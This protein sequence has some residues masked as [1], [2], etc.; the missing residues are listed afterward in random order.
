M[1]VSLSIYLANI[2]ISL[3]R[4]AVATDNPWNASSLEWATSSPPPPYNFIPSPTVA[5]R[6][7]LWEAPHVEVPAVVGLASDKR[8]VLVTQVMDA[9]PDH[10][11]EFPEPTIWPFLTAFATGA[12][13]LGSIFTPWA[14]IWGSIPIAVGLIGWAW[15][16][17]GHRPHGIEEHVAQAHRPATEHA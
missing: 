7:P 10:R 13:Y 6:E 16:R 11:K 17:K 1:F 15:P 5:G 4:G 2:V 14:V 9:E 8:E 3:R 12:M